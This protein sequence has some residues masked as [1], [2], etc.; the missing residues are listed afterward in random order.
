MAGTTLL[1]L[2]DD[3]ATLLDDVAILSK[4][5]VKK[6][7]GVLG[8]DLALNAQ[9]LTG[10]NPNRE[11]PVVWKVA[12]GSIINKVILVP[13]AL[14]ISAL[15]PWAVRPLLMI[16]GVYLCYEGCEKLLHK[17]LHGADHVDH[18]HAELAKATADPNID[19]VQFEKEKI[20]GAVRTDFVLSAEI[21]VIALGTVAEVEFTKRIAVLVAIAIIM[22]VGVYGLV[23]AIIKLDDLGK[24]L[25]LREGNGIRRLERMVGRVI[26]RIAPYLLK[27]L[28]IAGTAAMFI[29]GGG[30]IA[31]GFE[32]L[33][34]AIESLTHGL[35]D[36]PMGSWLA[37]FA[38]MILQA[39]S[40]FIAGSVVVGV[41]LLF[42][43]LFRAKQH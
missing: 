19:M 22:T 41:T 3:I 35:T 23:A 25:C 36:L 12:R 10:V 6:T 4:V 29:V 32:P 13:A 43:K 17:F 30:I 9:Q 11:L 21:I 28:S 20:A 7:A 37:N 42:G 8:D 34:H 16:G 26:L 24:F 14:L 5:A 38:I 31:H 18:S 15:A 2:I 40:G 27:L 33:H 39:L 1:T